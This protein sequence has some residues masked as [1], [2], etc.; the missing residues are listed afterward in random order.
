MDLFYVLLNYHDFEANNRIYAEIPWTL[1]SKVKITKADAGQ[2]PAAMIDNTYAFF[3][4]IA[5]IHK[6]SSLDQT[7]NLCIRDSAQR[8]IEFAL[9]LSTSTATDH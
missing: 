2:P 8:I 4:E 6:L 5:V 1:E 9:K 7:Q 3:L